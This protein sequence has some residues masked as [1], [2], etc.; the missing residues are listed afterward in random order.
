MDKSKLIPTQ[1]KILRQRAT[2]ILTAEI[3]A[4]KT[5]KLIREMRRELDLHEDGVA[6]AAPQIGLP[7]RVFILSKKF[8]PAAP[9]IYI[10][11]VIIKLSRKKVV[12]EEGC[13]SVRWKYG[14]VKRAERATIAAYD[15]QGRH[16]NRGASG[17][18]AQA[19]QHETDHLNGILFIDHATD[20]QEIKYEEGKSRILRNK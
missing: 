18:L 10:N 1:S 13:L 9:L 4:T 5:R 8:F 7:Y 19:F 14:K 6:L 16:F 11:P 15:E 2:E 17:L 3:R 12:L 20:L